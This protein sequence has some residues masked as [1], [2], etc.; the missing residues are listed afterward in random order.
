[1]VCDFNDELREAVTNAFPDCYFK[2][3]FFHYIKNIW[4]KTKYFWLC[5]KNIIE[6]IKKLF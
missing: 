1:M 6:K 2:G 4:K 5:R 3:C